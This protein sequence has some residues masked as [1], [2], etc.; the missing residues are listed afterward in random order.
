MDLSSIS[1]RY[2]KGV[3]AKREQQLNKLGIASVSDLLF[4]FPREYQDWTPC[5]DFSTLVPEQKAMI[6]GRIAFVR[7]QSVRRNRMM[8]THLAVENGGSILK[9]TFFNQKYVP[10]SFQPGAYI[11]VYGKI[12]MYKHALQM[13]QIMSWQI[14]DHKPSL[15][16]YSGLHPVYPACESVPQKFLMKVLSLTLCEYGE[17][18]KDYFPDSMRN[19]LKVPPLFHT[20]LT[21]HQ[22]ENMKELMK[23]RYAMQIREAFFPCLYW[24]FS[25]QNVIEQPYSFHY[26]YPVDVLREF[27]RRL[28]FSLTQA[29]KRVIREIKDDLD[30]LKPMRRLLQGDVGSGKTIVAFISSLFVLASGYQTAF[31]VPTEILARQHFQKI[32]ELVK[33]FELSDFVKPVLLLGGGKAKDKRELLIQIKEGQVNLI[34]GTHALFQDQ[35]KYHNLSYV[36]VDEQHR[37]GVKQRGALLGKADNPDVLIMTATP[38]PRTLTMTYYGDLDL[39]LIDQLPAGRKAIAT[40]KVPARKKDKMIGFC[41]K[42]LKENGQIYIVCPL[43]EESDKLDLKAATQAYSEYCQHFPDVKCALIHGK[44]PPEDKKQIMENFSENKVQVLVS[45]VVIEVGVDVPNANVMLIEHP[46]R[47]GL[48]Q[49][50]QLRGRIGRSDQQAWC[51][52]LISDE[53]ESDASSRLQHLVDSND[54]F[55]LSRFDLELRGPG[56]FAG[57]RQHGF[58]Q[59]SFLNLTNA[60]PLLEK[61]RKYVQQLVSA[62]P[63]LKKQEHQALRAQ[64][65]KLYEHHLKYLKI[66]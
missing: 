53:C 49:L 8:L 60:R 52:L 14:F 4:Y 48:S 66:H 35:V 39:S 15:E 54:G 24:E 27:V 23:A 50:H 7:R 5:E 28:P 58:H 59:F 47:F 65:I 45:T 19:V 51:F 57:I 55:E 21:L 17:K 9:I 56:E 63:Y 22:P 37:F 20:V 61:V 3:G 2:C 33:Q 32:C 26:Q 18:I 25:R 62:D 43:I 11:S 31:M 13:S 1:I 38:I 30:A 44:M 40:K 6:I 42:Y 41:R 46:E 16:D 10:E 29:Q 12:S 34:I 64:F 36:I